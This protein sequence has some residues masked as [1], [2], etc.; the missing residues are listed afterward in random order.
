MSQSMMTLSNGNIFRVTGHLCGKI[1]GP[2]WIPR[3]KASDAGLWFFFDLRL[4]KRLSRQS[5]VWWFE[6]LSRL[7][8]RHYNAIT[9]VHHDQ[10]LW[11]IYLS[12]IVKRSGNYWNIADVGIFISYERQGI[13]N[14]RQLSYF[15]DSLLTTRLNYAILA[16]SLGES[17]G[18]RRIPSHS[19][20]KAGS[21]LCHG[22]IIVCA[23]GQISVTYNAQHESLSGPST[24]F[25][26]FAL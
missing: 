14:H 25:Y 20:R 6:T 10:V 5:R 7:L 13:Y 15:F 17:T 16:H 23:W 26:S 22:V 12:L 18:H 24:A 2:R 8:W 4:N 3:T 11:H 9:W 19:T 21:F 1:V